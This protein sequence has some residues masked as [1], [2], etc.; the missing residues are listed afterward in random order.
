MAID[1][2]DV[3]AAQKILWADEVVGITVRQRRVGPGG[4]MTTPTSVIGTDKRLI[5]LNRA[6]LGLRQDYEAIPY[7]QI[8]SVRFEHGIISSSVFIRVEGYSTDQGLLKKGDQEG[9]IDGLHNADAQ[10][11]ADFINRKLDTTVLGDQSGPPPAQGTPVGTITG[12]GPFTYCPKCGA[13]N[14]PGAKFCTECGT[15]LKS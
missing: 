11:L 3:K 5:I 8:T 9:E 6:T 13:K 15:A 2:S 10:A 1:P 4:A 12:K 14:D 7:R